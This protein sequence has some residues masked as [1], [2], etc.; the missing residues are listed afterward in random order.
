M[1]Y[2]IPS[3]RKEFV[4]ITAT[5]YSNMFSAFQSLYNYCYSKHD[6]VYDDKDFSDL[7]DEIIDSLKLISERYKGINGRKR[8]FVNKYVDIIKTSNLTLEYM[9]IH[10]I[11]KYIYILDALPDD[12]Y[13]SIMKDY[14]DVVKDAV[15]DRDLIT[16]SD[17]FAPSDNDVAVYLV[18]KRLIYV[19]V[20]SKVGLSK[21]S[22][23]NI[24]AYL[25]S[26]KVI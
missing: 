4:S 25:N 12:K 5:N 13:V 18:L 20:L 10:E 15:H 1:T 21:N 17:V 3:D 19:M 7:K 8:K 23:K 11:E 9:I 22:I 26:S 24:I 16:H 6:V 14:H 2:S